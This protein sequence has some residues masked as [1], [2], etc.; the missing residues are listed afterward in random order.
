MNVRASGTFADRRCMRLFSAKAGASLI[1][2]W[3]VVG[4]GGGVS[5]PGVSRAEQ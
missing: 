1:A 5:E 2:S 4:C 3:T